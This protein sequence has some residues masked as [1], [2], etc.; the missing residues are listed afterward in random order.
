MKLNRLSKPLQSH[1]YI[2]FQE[3]K[4]QGSNLH[5]S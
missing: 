5:G 1:D 3:R 2:N 4:Q